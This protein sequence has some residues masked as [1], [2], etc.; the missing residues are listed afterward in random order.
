MTIDEPTRRSLYDALVAS[1]GETE[2]DTLMSLLPHYP[3]ADL[4]TRDDMHSLAI[5]LRGEMAELRSELHGEMAVG[6]AAVDRRFGEIQGQFGKIDARFGKIDGQF[7][8]LRGE[9]DGQLG[10][11]RGEIAKLS[12]E[13]RAEFSQQ[14][15]MLGLLLGGSILA[16]L[17]TLLTLGFT[18][19]FA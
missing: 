3:L 15:L 14:V 18:G 9:I 2:A 6:F 5:A 13:L 12:G 7:G 4:A 16:V 8:E 1:L 19:A 10:E 11:I 17:G